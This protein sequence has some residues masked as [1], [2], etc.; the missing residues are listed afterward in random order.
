MNL[1]LCQLSTQSQLKVNQPPFSSQ[2]RG[3]QSL[4]LLWKTRTS[5]NEL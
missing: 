3:K 5:E 2:L 1:Q 4:L